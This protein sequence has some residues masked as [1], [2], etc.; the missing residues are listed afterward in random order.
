MPS[1]ENKIGTTILKLQKQVIKM[2]KAFKKWND[3]EDIEAKAIALQG[4]DKEH[5]K[6]QELNESL[7]A[8]KVQKENK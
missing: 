7:D 5:E 1:I 3:E 2:G 4:L 6:L 8:L